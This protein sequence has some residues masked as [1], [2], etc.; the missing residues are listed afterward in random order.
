MMMKAD[1]AVDSHT[2]PQVVKVRIKASKTDPYRPGVDIFLGRTHK[3]LCP[4]TAILSYMRQRGSE[5]G[6]LFKFANGKPLTRPRF[7]SRIREALTQA[8]IN[9]APYL[10]HSFRI[11]AATTAASQ[12]I[13]DTT[14]KMHGKVEEWSISTLYKDPPG[15]TGKYL[16]KAGVM[17]QILVVVS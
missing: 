7:V 14:I 9:C 17:R 2:D 15:A 12:E 13:E 16:Q 8:G 3:S 10:G 1:V 4:V 6:P 11:G 5:P